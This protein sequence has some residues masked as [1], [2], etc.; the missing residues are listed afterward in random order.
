[1]KGP[2]GFSGESLTADTLFDDLN[3]GVR[4]LYLAKSVQL[5]KSLQL[6]DPS[7]EKA[8]EDVSRITVG[9]IF[10]SSLL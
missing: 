3:N 7:Y 1:M 4:L 10:Q 8:A 2:F 9:F 5:I 6:K